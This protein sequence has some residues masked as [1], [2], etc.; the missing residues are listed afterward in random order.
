MPA[1]P[2]SRSAPTPVASPAVQ[3]PGDHLLTQDSF[4]AVLSAHQ[5]AGRWEAADEIEVRA[6]FGAVTL[7]F[8]RAELPPSGM[9]EIDVLAFC[10]AVEI[11][12]PDGAEVEL[13]GTPVLGSIEQKLRKLGARESIPA[14]VTGEHDENLPAS[15]P[16]PEPP[17]FRIDCRAILGSI[18]V[19]GR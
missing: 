14:R 12:V 17:Y 10:G 15:A 16:P 13:D 3:T 5:R 1:M 19:M 8:T 6:I 7:D 18:E 4:Q 9:I 2:D 11:I